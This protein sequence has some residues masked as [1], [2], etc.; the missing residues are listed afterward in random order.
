M[1]NTGAGYGHNL[2]G[3]PGGALGSLGYN[4]IAN[5]SELHK[6]NKMIEGSRKRKN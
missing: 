1:K 4:D 2:F 5:Y 6:S 3:I